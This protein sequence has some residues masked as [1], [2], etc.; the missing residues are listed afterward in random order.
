MKTNQELVKEIH[1]EFDT[2]ADEMLA[3]A[4]IILNIGFS[5]Q[6]EDRLAKLGFARS[7]QAVEVDKA[8]EQKKLILQYRQTYPAHKFV[9]EEVVKQIC[10]KYGL[11]LGGVSNF[12]GEVPEKNLAEIEAFKVKKEDY[13]DTNSWGSGM[14]SWATSFLQTESRLFRSGIDPFS[15]TW[16][17]DPA[18]PMGFITSKPRRWGTGSDLAQAYS[19]AMWA[20]YRK[21]EAEKS[22]FHEKPLFQICAPENEFNTQGLKKVGHELVPEDPI[23]LCPV[24]G[25][26]LVVTK[27]GLEASDPSVRDERMN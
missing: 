4:N 13:R 22:L 15:P 1:T 26:Y 18:T 14:D 20:D 19:T 12:I 2:A 6:K 11:L 3:E 9:T 16:G 7:K 5:Q 21:K 25:G 17:I 27:W 10:E 24:T 8:G 23:V